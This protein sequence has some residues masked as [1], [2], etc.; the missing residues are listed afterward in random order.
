MHG[1]KKWGGKQH[2]L[3]PTRKSEGA[4]A[5]PFAPAVPRSVQTDNRRISE[6]EKYSVIKIAIYS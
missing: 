2:C 3:P 4:I 6:Y 5:S 1:H